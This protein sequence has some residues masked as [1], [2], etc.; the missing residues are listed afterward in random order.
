MICPDCNDTR[1]YRGLIVVEPC[2]S[3]RPEKLITLNEV[4]KSDKFQFTDPLNLRDWL[5]TKGW[6]PM[7]V[8][9]CSRIDSKNRIW[10]DSKDLSVGLVASLD[11]HGK[12]I[13]KIVS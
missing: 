5:E 4:K 10:F 3:C 1:Q 13:I 11:R 7:T 2:K 6:N 9:T 8:L 12:C